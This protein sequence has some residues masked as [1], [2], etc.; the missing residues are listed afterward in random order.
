MPLS[1]IDQVRLQIGD[2]DVEEQYLD[3]AQVQFFLDQNGNSVLDTA[4]ECLEVIIASIALSPKELK[5]G[6]ITEKAPDVVLLENR[7]KSLKEKKAA[8]DKRMPFIVKSD[9][10]NWNDIDSLYTRQ[11][12]NQFNY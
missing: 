6:E 11:G 3:D 4:I 5:V 9:R 1:K 2:T 10:T 8:G 12:N 7:L